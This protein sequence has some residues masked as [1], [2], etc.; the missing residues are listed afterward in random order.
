V[1]YLIRKFFVFENISYSDLP[2][3]VYLKT[4]SFLVFGEILSYVNVNVH[5]SSCKVPVILVM[6]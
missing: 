4:S 2:Y 1:V 5:S 3:D 6:F